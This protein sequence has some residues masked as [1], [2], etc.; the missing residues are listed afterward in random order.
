MGVTMMTFGLIPLGL[1]PLGE[2]ISRYG[3][4]DAVLGM[5]IILLVVAFAFLIFMSRLRSLE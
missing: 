2:A 4:Q 5:S 1:L 3:A